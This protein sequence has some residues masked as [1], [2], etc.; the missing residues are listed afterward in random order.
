MGLSNNKYQGFSRSSL[1]IYTNGFIDIIHI[2][3]SAWL[4]HY[5]NEKKIPIVPNWKMI[6]LHF[7][8]I[9]CCLKCC[10][11]RKEIDYSRHILQIVWRWKHFSLCLSRKY[12]P[13]K[14][15]NPLL[16]E[17]CINYTVRDEFRNLGRS[18]YCQ[19]IDVLLLQQ[20]LNTCV[21][22]IYISPF[23]GYLNNKSSK[24]VFFQVFR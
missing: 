12:L 13:N 23:S 6:V 3:Y 8:Q 21:I 1:K 22:I 15:T 5:N 2:Y 9:K 7:N 24:W 14:P 16:H 11:R 17:P 19:Q 20:Q 18:L 10:N 4:K